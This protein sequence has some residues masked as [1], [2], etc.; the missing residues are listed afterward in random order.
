MGEPSDI[1]ELSGRKVS[2][3][4]VAASAGGPLTSR[5]SSVEGSMGQRG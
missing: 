1:P 3:A 5:P 4:S 2:L